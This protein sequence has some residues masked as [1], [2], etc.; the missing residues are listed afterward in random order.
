MPNTYQELAEQQKDPTKEPKAWEI[1]VEGY[2]ASG[3]SSTAMLVTKV[4][5]TT[6]LEA[7]TLYVISLDRASQAYWRFNKDNERWSY[8]GCG[9][10]DNEADARE[11]FG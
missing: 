10:F 4:T 8:W 5:A 7:C 9:A 6:F 2:A 3:D 11:S 1:W